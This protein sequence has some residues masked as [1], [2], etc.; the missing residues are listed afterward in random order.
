ML[1]LPAGGVGLAF[2]GQ[3]RRE[4][5]EQDIDPLNNGDIV[6]SGQSSS[7]R[8][9]R[10]S[11]G[12]YA[13]TDLPVFSSANSIP[14]FHALNFTAAAR[15]EAFRSNDTNVLVPKFGM[16]WQPFDESL[17]LRS[18]WGEGFLQPTLF[19]LFGSSSSGFGGAQGDT[20]VTVNTNPSLQPEDSRNFTAGF[21]YSP[22]FLPGLTFSF[23]LWNIET[24]GVVYL[25]D[26][27]D[28]LRRDDDGQLLTGE[29]VV[30]D[31][32]SGEV[33]RI[34]KT[35]QNGGSERARG[36]DLSLQYQLQT[37]FGTFTSLTQATYID[38]FRQ[39]ASPGAPALEVSNAA[40]GDSS[41]A[42]L[43]WKAISR[44]DWRWKGLD[45]VATVRYTD[46]FSKSSCMV[47]FSRTQERTLQYIEPWSFDTQ[48]TYDFAFARPV[49]TQPAASWKNWLNNASI[50]IG[51]NNVFGQDPP[52][53][54][55]SM[56]TNP[57]GYPF[58]IYDGT[59]RFVYVSLKKKF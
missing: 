38:S 5:I 24:N 17:T 46:G 33:T 16:R 36:V 26:D 45:V 56:F 32:D 50:T 30:H 31:P 10:K 58:F 9:G 4:A 55:G 3:F 13:E 27:A 22:K 49:E 48:A 47:L 28:I 44:L 23:D 19:Q 21:V 8:A 15:F 14:A 40:F 6:G 54:Y 57:Y 53:A 12:I 51:C 52:K 2:G 11:Y 43:K 35:F 37:P 59:G 39:A 20:P 41:D 7:T 18:T 42:Y 34:I 1:K 29:T 25:P